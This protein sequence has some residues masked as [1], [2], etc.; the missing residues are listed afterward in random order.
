M[1]RKMR[2]AYRKAGVTE[3]E[4]KKVDQP[5]VADRMKLSYQNKLMEK[6]GITVATFSALEEI[7]GMM[8]KV[9]SVVDNKAISPEANAISKDR[10]EIL[11]KA[12]MTLKKEERELLRLIYD[13]MGGNVSA[14]AEKLDMSRETVRDRNNAILRK[15]ENYFKK[16]GL[17]YADLE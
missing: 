15:L 6:L 10:T 11:H 17:S 12:L 3:E 8:D 16:I 13:E 9:M 1:D 2:E 14:A 4:I 5:F 7:P